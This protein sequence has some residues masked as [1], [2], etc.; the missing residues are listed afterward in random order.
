MLILELSCLWLTVYTELI[1]HS[2]INYDFYTTAVV[3]CLV[4]NICKCFILIG[5]LVFTIFEHTQF[6]LNLGDRNY[7]SLKWFPAWT[8]PVE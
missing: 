6:M 5:W 4:H 1:P 8:I 2:N 3:V 7:A